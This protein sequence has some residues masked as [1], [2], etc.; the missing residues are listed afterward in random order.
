MANLVNEGAVDRVIRVVLGLILGYIATRL[1]GAGAIILYIL[2]AISFLTGVSGICL[3][4]MLFGIR[5]CPVRPS[6]Q[7]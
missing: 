3:L 4:Y 1:S 5:T 2:A 7:R 6:T